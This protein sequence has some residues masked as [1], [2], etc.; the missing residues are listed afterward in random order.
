MRNFKKFSLGYALLLLW[1]VLSFTP[2]FAH[3]SQSEDTKQQEPAETEVRQEESPLEP[4]PSSEITLRSEGTNAELNKIRSVL[5]PDPRIAN[6]RR[7]ELE[8]LDVLN[9]SKENF[10]AIDIEGL[11][12][13]Q[14]YEIR[15]EWQIHR[16]GVNTWHEA[17]AV[18][19]ETLESKNV[20]LDQIQ[21]LWELTRISA[22]EQN[23]PNALKE[24]INLI[25]G[26]IG[27]VEKRLQERLEEVFSLQ[28]HLSDQTVEINS[29][30][31]EIETAIGQSRQ[32][33]FSQDSPPLWKALF[34][35]KEE[36]PLSS[37]IKEIWQKKSDTLSLYLSNN[38]DR[39]LIN[40]LVFVVLST[41][42]FKFLRNSQE[43]S[44]EDEELNA[45]AGIFKYPFS[46]ALLISLLI[47]TWIFPQTPLIF[48]E[49][50]AVLFLIPLIRLVP[51]LVTPK[52]RSFLYVLGG[53]YLLN[54]IYEQMPERSSIQRVL[55]FIIV[56]LALVGLAWMLKKGGVLEKILEGNEKKV[57][58]FLARI[59][60]VLL[61]VAWFANIFGYV[62]L[63]NLC[64]EGTFFSIYAFVILFVNVIVLEGLLAA[65]LRSDTGKSLRIFRLHTQLWKRKIST[66]LR[67]GAVVLWFYHTLKNFSVLDPA[68]N[69]LGRVIESPLKIGS[70]SISLGDVIAFL[71]TL[72]LSILLAR[73]IRFV[74]GEDVLPRLT[75]PRGVPGAI[76]FVA[77]YFILIVGF[78]FALSAAGIELS[79]FALL[80]GA[81]GIGIGFGL[82][83][84]VNNFVS[85]LILVFERPI[86][87]GDMIEFGSQRG[88]VLR[89]GIRSSTIRNWEGAE[90]I[91][92]NGNLISGEVVNWTLSDRRRRI[93]VSL[94]VTYG[95]DPNKVLE[96]LN[97]V[98]KDHSSVLD[99]P[100]PS[101]LFVGF[102]ESSLDFELR[103]SIPEFDD[104]LSVKSEIT[105]A[106]NNALKDA[107]IEI[108][109]PQRD[110][111]VR[112][113]DTDAQKELM[114]KKD[115]PKENKK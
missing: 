92:P 87:V 90:V 61:T 13:K 39:L 48:S 107:K 4:I 63:A 111:H 33:L 15:D 73:F 91:V 54:S 17:V 101:A 114:P 67:F 70:L 35:P 106:I 84:L 104:W 62:Y 80:A 96:I 74:L 41:L 21:K 113:I 32:R 103:F 102:G 58:N 69:I 60:F 76:S 55:L 85:G 42:L 78:L 65:F 47:S 98:A 29:V 88:Q 75:L 49:L 66:F 18:R 3:T 89:I 26:E 6:I 38:W 81:V 72:W 22:A 83:N 109:F 108:P 37:Q 24:R 110:L 1:M 19:S 43:W 27:E 97:D 31:S 68:I 45:L 14:L 95:T 10:Q 59:A 86:K 23:Y 51:G 9:K 115:M 7:E 8:F 82:Q 105:L 25:L 5:N 77:Y 64:V 57:G 56:S 11:S 79:R 94:G 12:L 2:L 20:E 28:G 46:I 16:M 40:L 99:T 50:R 100:A 30:L 36:I 52:M 93:K 71:I 53:F 34:A 112:S 44:D